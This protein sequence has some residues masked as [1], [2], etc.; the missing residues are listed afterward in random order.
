LDSEILL[1]GALSPFVS[2]SVNSLLVCVFSL[3]YSD[4]P[5]IL[6]SYHSMTTAISSKLKNSPRNTSRGATFIA[7]NL[8]I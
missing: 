3:P 8:I 7:I 1:F 5:A 6:M 4:I 2:I